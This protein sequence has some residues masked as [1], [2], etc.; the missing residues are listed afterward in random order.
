MSRFPPAILTLLSLVA[1]SNSPRQ[2]TAIVEVAAGSTLLT[3]TGEVLM[4][5]PGA[6]LR[7]LD[8]VRELL[9]GDGITVTWS[10]RNAGVILADVLRVQSLVRIDPLLE[11]PTPELARL[12]EGGGATVI[13]ARNAAAFAAGHLSG[14]VPLDLTALPESPIVF[15]GSGPRDEEAPAAL[16]AALARGHEDARVYLSG[17]AHWQ[18]TGHHTIIEVEHLHRVLS[19]VLLIDVRDR[20]DIAKATIAGAHGMPV[21]ELDREQ[22]ANEAWMPPLVFFGEDASDERATLAAKRT[23]AWRYRDANGPHVPVHVLEGGLAAW[24]GAGRPIVSGADAPTRFR[25]APDPASGEL[26]KSVFRTLV[27][28]PGDTLLLDVRSPAAHS[29]AWATHI[30][31]EQLPSRIDELPRDG[32]IV[33]FCNFGKRSRIA[34]V[35][36]KRNGFDVRYLRA[37]PTF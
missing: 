24:K 26:T 7:G 2:L 30:P 31:L 6:S 34:R 4:L 21:A 23:I 33:T 36:L 18:R 20:N 12:L 14:A 35:I 1:C 13:D 29:P 16:R 27:N 8:R 19:E 11:V 37:R 9:P 22:L 25:Y 10:R 28:D 17:V 15:Y 3:T 5:S 32:P